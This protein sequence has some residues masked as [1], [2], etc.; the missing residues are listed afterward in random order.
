MFTVASQTVQ[1]SVPH[2]MWSVT[3]TPGGGEAIR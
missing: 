1:F 2:I 3:S